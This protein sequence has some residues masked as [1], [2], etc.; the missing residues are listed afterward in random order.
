MET[1]VTMTWMKL[2]YN[3]LLV[4]SDSKYA[5]QIEKT[6]YNALL[7]SMKFD[8]EE[9]AKYSPLEG[10]RHA[11]EEQ[12]GMH[13]NCCNANGPRG[14]TLMP[15]FAYLKSGN[16]IFVNF[17]GQSEAKIE[18]DNNS[19]EIKQL[20][21]YPVSDKIKLAINPEKEGEFKLALRIPGW[22]KTTALKVNGVSSSGMNSGDYFFINRDWKKGDKVELTFDLNARIMRQNHYQS[23]VRGPVV[24]ARDSRFSDG[25][26]DE[27]A[28]I[29]TSNGVVQ[30][31][32]VA[33]KPESV[34][35]AF[36]APLVLGTDLEGEFKE[37]RMV[38][39]CDFA[40]AGNTWQE[41]TRYRVWIPQTLNVMNQNYR[42]Y[43]E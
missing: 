5:D 38:T 26:V 43:Q 37:P 7:A 16:T 41:G 28:R 3:L 1:C 42:N 19:V 30:L 2:C 27:G 12:C 31:T 15:S 39:F 36:S 24:F 14:F 11:G 23:I 33:D 40:S 25:F 34:W 8:A 29:V 10:R 35:M 6:F 21:N 13:I 17:Y 18:L 32:P 4:T 22:S 9:I 20:T